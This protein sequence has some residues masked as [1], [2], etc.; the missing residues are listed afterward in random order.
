M[1]VV[2]FEL[3]VVDEVVECRDV[4]L[5]DRIAELAVEVESE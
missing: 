3:A 2:W 5:F 1:V 4:A